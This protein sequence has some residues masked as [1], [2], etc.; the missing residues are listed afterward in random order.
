[1]N[2]NL[3]NIRNLSPNILK[4]LNK[5]IVNRVGCTKDACMITKDIINF[6]SPNHTYRFESDITLHLVEALSENKVSMDVLSPPR[7]AVITGTWNSNESIV[8]PNANILGGM[9]MLILDEHQS[10][11]IPVITATA[12]NLAFYNA[13]LLSFGDTLC[14]ETQQDLPLTEMMIGNDYVDHF[15]SHEQQ[16]GGEY[17]EHHVEPHF[18]APKHGNCGGHILLGRYEQGKFYFTGF[19][20]PFGHAVYLS[21]HILHSDAYLIGDYLVAY[22][23][24]ET[25]STVL[26]RDKAKQSKRL[27]FISKSDF[28]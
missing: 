23:V 10:L 26:F 5:L 20:I 21:P 17:I 24:T 12:E 3:K 11:Q 25:Y 2:D 14:F 22:T 4:N 28:S 9:G 18:W 13:R 27:E 15:L 16:G 19:S 8:N 6:V 1:M 7:H